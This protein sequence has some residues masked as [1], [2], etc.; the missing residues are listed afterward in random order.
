LS[1]ACRVTDAHI[2]ATKFSAQA[3]MAVSCGMLV[4]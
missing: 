4:V 3:I 1:C 2:N